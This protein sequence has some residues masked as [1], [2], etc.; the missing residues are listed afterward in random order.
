MSYSSYNKAVGKSCYKICWYYNGC[1][2]FPS[3]FCTRI[4]QIFIPTNSPEIANENV[5]YKSLVTTSLEFLV[6]EDV[7]IQ[8]VTSHLG[9]HWQAL[10]MIELWFTTW[11]VH[12]IWDITLRT[13]WE[14]VHQQH[15]DSV[16]V[17]ESRKEHH[18]MSQVA[19]PLKVTSTRLQW[20]AIEA[21]ADFRG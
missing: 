5:S 11:D 4:F 15:C 17:A 12:G 20:G 21:N 2:I 8:H 13:G 1:S 6:Q 14:F 10:V 3:D 16:V 18:K 19:R 9:G 7:E